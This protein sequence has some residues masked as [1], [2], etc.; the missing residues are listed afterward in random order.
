MSS[1][2]KTPHDDACE[3]TLMLWGIVWV[4]YREEREEFEILAFRCDAIAVV[5]K[6]DL[7]FAVDIRP[8]LLQFSRN[9]P[10]PSVQMTFPTYERT[11][12]L[13]FQSYLY[14]VLS[15]LDKMP[16][17]LLPLYTIYIA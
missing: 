3:F 12:R 2:N 9:F 10:F 13:N 8:I 17:K 5:N 1:G 7:V 6:F 4:D 11:N 16:S 15:I 14:Y